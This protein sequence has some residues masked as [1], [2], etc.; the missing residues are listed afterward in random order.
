MC[1]DVYLEQLLSPPIQTVP[2]VD[3]QPILRQDP[4]PEALV[5]VML[6]PSCF[7]QNASSTSPMWTQASAGGR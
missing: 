6:Q 3:L 7:N 4:N 5:G 2:D 1:A